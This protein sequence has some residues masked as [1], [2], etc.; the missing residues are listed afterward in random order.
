[1]TLKLFLWRINIYLD[2]MFC[3]RRSSKAIYRYFKSSDRLTTN[4]PNLYVLSNS[5]SCVSQVLWTWNVFSVSF[6]SVPKTLYAILYCDC[7]SVTNH[8]CN[9]LALF[10]FRQHLRQ[11]DKSLTHKNFSKLHLIPYFTIEGLSN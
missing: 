11:E 9:A 3:W 6:R 2:H 7:T 10:H 1:V 5:L 8:I 4:F